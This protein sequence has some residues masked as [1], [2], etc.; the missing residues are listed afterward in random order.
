[1]GRVLAAIVE[2]TSGRHDTF[3]G[4]T[5]R[6]R[7]RGRATATARPTARAPTGATTSA[8]PSPSTASAAATSPRTS[9]CSRASGSSPTARCAFDGDPRPGAHVELRL[10][11]PLLVTVV[12]VPH[13]LDPRPDYTVTPLRVTAWRGEPAAPDDP[14]RTATPEGERAYLNTEQEAAR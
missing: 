11:L 10:E 3:C 4:T 2:D 5:N 1:M 14:I 8:S 13:P 12:N 9:T 7:Q 6:A